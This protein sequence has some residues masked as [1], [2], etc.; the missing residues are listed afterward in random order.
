[1]TLEEITQRL[2]DAQGSTD[3]MA[4]LLYDLQSPRPA[5]P[6]WPED[7]RGTCTDIGFSPP[8]KKHYIGDEAKAR[9]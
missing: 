5:K 4:R 9:V 1:M 6:K 7:D 2:D 3:V 8:I